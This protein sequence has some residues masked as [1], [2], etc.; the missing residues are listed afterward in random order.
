MGLILVALLVA[1]GSIG[2]GHKEGVFKK[3]Y[4]TTAKDTYAFEK[5]ALEMNLAKTESKRMTIIELGNN[6]S[7]LAEKEAQLHFR[8]N[9][10]KAKISKLKQKEDE[11]NWEDE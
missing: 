11:K 10:L 9:I 7:A 1:A 5:N 2:I 8:E 3:G 4:D 6:D